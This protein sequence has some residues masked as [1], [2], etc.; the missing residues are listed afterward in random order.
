MTLVPRMAPTAGETMLYS[1][2]VTFHLSVTGWPGPPEVVA[3]KLLM[4]GF[5][6]VGTF[7]GV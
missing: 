1:P 7:P 5:G 2:L 6:P 4:V 3:V